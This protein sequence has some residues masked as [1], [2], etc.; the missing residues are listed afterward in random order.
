[1]FAWWEVVT[2]GFFS[3]MPSDTWGHV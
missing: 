1:M 3:L 2:N